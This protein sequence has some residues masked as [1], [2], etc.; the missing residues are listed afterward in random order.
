MVT[1]EEKMEARDKV[2]GFKHTLTDMST[3]GSQ[4]MAPFGITKER[5]KADRRTM[6]RSVPGRMESS[7]CGTTR[8]AFSP[9][10]SGW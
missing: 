2:M 1:T 3:R 6:E 8:S 9:T 4:F 5:G 7:S 10:E